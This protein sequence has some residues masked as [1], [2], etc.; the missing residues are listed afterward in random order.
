MFIIYLDEPTYF[1][2][3]SKNHPNDNMWLS[4]YVI[5]LLNW[6]R[7]DTLNEIMH[8]YGVTCGVRPCD[9]LDSF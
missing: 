3:N 7:K 2:K 9:N 5:I 8:A 6:Y 4:K 1:S